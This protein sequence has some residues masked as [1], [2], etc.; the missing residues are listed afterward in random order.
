MRRLAAVY[1]GAPSRHFERPPRDETAVELH[2]V[3]GLHGGGVAHVGRLSLQLGVG[4]GSRVF[5]VVVVGS[6]HLTRLGLVVVDVK[7]YNLVLLIRV[8]GTA[9]ARTRVRVRVSV[10]VWIRVRV[11]V[12]VRVGIGLGLG[13]AILPV[14]GWW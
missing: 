3:L 1:D 5:M 2:P 6:G 7:D 8:R 14:L 10:R 13:V 9:R 12:R 4:F 11:R